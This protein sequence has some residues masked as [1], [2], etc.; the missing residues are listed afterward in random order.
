MIIKYILDPIRSTL[1]ASEQSLLDVRLGWVQ[2][3]TS[4]QQVTLHF[5]RYLYS[6]WVIRN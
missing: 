6:R 4:A 1:Y 2:Y 5:T 3:K